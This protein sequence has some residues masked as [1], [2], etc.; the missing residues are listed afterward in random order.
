MQSP[1]FPFLEYK[2]LL[3]VGQEQRSVYSRI[4]E[5]AKVSIIVLFAVVDNR[6][7]MMTWYD[8]IT[9]FWKCHTPL[10]EDVTHTTICTRFVRT[11]CHEIKRK[12]TL[13]KKGGATSLALA[14]TNARSNVMQNYA[15]P[16]FYTRFQSSTNVLL[17]FDYS[18][19]V[20]VG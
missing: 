5:G 19:H 3:F 4:S 12:V 20:F 16:L 18:V 2:F 15:F 17:R 10:F 13:T 11:R 9:L 6:V 14:T 7:L 8:T 1:L